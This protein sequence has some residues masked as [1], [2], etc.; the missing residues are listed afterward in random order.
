MFSSCHPARLP[1]EVGSTMQGTRNMERKEAQNLRNVAE[2]E[3]LLLWGSTLCPSRCKMENHPY[4]F[5]R[6]G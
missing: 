4:G 5:T 6:W 3:F 1:L 2:S